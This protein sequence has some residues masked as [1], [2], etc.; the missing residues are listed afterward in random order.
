MNGLE[1]E[2]RKKFKGMEFK[3]L[4]EICS[5]AMRYEWI[6]RKKNNRHTSSTG[7]YYVDPNYEIDLTKIIS[8]KPYVCLAIQ[9]KPRG[10]NVIKTKKVT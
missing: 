8:K 3:D 1:I 2:Q 6:L 9:R 4:F 5:R 7:T 10:N